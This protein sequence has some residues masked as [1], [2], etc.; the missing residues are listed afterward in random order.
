MVFLA[1][2]LLIL[3][4]LTSA[5][6]LDSLW[7]KSWGD[8][9]LDAVGL[10]LQGIA[11]PILQIVVL[12]RLYSVLMPLLHNSLILNPA[13]ALLLS[14]VGVD[15]VYYWNHRLLHTRSL[16]QLHLVHHTVSSMDVLGTSR[17]TVWTSF[18]IVYLWIHSLFIYLLQDP[19]WY[20]IGVSLT[21]VLDLWR[22]S[23]F[24]PKQNSWL[25]AL[26]NPWLILPQD[27]AWHHAS[28]AIACNFG[29]NLKLWDR[30]HGTYS[31]RDRIPKSLGIKTDLTLR[32]RLIYPFGAIDRD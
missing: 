8:W 6:G 28:E 17:N 29:A 16:W 18:L 20:I 31:D 21:S 11:I 24:S 7:G 10:I 19:S 2:S 3:L 22:H 12:N 14:F 1:F 4:T 27:H 25:Y 15:Y 23:E 5:K 9:I 32:Q 26:L 30:I 13:M